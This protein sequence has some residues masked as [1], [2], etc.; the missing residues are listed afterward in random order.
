[1]PFFFPPIC[2]S[3]AYGSVPRG[4]HIPTDSDYPPAIPLHKPAIN[5]NLS[6][7]DHAL[8]IFIE[9]R[10]KQL[11]KKGPKRNFI[12]LFPIERFKAINYSLYWKVSSFV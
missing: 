7:K 10:E 1:M 3:Y 2:G 4:D 5:I 8:K 6:N 11:P 9:L 12:I